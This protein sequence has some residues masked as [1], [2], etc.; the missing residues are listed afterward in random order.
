MLNRA[1]LC[2]ECLRIGD[3]LR[4]TTGERVDV[5]K[6]TAKVQLVAVLLNIAEVWRG[7]HVG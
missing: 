6:R 5:L 4:F 3:I 1:Y 2:G 7:E